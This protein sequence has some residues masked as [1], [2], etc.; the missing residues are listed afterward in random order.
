MH[1]TERREQ[2]RALIGSE[3]CVNPGSVYD[4]VS[5]RV[6]EHV[7]YEVMV[8]P[9]SIAS[10]AVLGA[11]DVV[12]MTLSELAGLTSRIN[13]A[14]TL[15]LLVDADH[16]FGNAL[17]VRRTI[18]ELESAGAAAITIED[19][20]LPKPFASSA[21]EFVTLE[22]GVA[23]MKAA[24][25]ARQDP[26]LSVLART[27]TAGSLGI[28]EAVRRARAYEK[29]GVD[30]LFFTGITERSDL[31]KLS[32]ETTLPLFLVHSGDLTDLE[33]LAKLRVRIRL[34]PHLPFQ[35]AMRAVFETMAALHGGTPPGEL[36]VAA[37][38]DL[39]ATALEEEA[40]KMW[41][42]KFLR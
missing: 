24:L 14:G 39:Q 36:D 11:P 27:N 33:E 12:V 4:A 19:T 38:K 16:G 15:P 13:R 5:A 40:Y 42:E 3:R 41:S 32:A 25:D 35:A 1:W 26:A 37:S 34:Q 6:A 30:G 10:M 29:A 8:L 31:E 21:M 2:F 28:D 23:K 9:G 20:I 22:E 18:E 7:G 17:N